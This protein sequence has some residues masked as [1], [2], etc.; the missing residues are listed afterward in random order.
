MKSR[1]CQDGATVAICCE[2]QQ[3][4]CTRLM[5]VN[6]QQL[7]LILVVDITSMYFLLGIASIQS[8]KQLQFCMVKNATACQNKNQSC[9]R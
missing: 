3:T 8:C 5:W 2:H 4:T 7:I 6:H 9:H 1:I